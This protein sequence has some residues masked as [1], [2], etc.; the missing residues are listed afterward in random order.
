MLHSAVSLLAKGE[1][2]AQVG[3]LVLDGNEEGMLPCAEA[4]M[5]SAILFDL[6]GTGVLE[7]CRPFDLEDEFGLGW[8]DVHASL[9]QDSKESGDFAVH[10]AHVF[11]GVENPRTQVIVGED[12]VRAPPGVLSHAS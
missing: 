5:P 10:T 2:S 1:D 6:P 4:P 11:Q 9:R 7:G 12:S 8:T 3:D